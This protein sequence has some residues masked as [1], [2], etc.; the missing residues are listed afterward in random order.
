[1]GAGFWG[2]VALMLALTALW[3]GLGV[4]QI[5]RLQWKEGLIAEVDARLTAQPYDLP[6]ATA[7]SAMESSTFDYHPVTLSGQYAA[8]EPVLVFTSLT[9]PKGKYAG[10]GYW[11]MTPFTPDGG[12]TVFIN[13]G[14]VP[15]DSSR[16]FLDQNTVPKGHLSLTGIALPPEAPGPFTPPPDR[17]NHVDWIANASRLA[18]FD[19]ISG[20]VFPLTVDLPAGPRGALP[21]GGETTVDFP[22]NHLGYAFTW[23]GLAI[24]TPA[25]LA[26][27]VWRQVRPKSLPPKSLPR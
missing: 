26:Y 18:A 16:A 7:W 10:A 6:P 20:P 21:Q 15:Q 4:W 24:L 5:E 19:G 22:N 25:L 3:I 27:W 12:G 11:I 1:M 8:A 2:F 17:T 14:F 9:E 13:R 23:F